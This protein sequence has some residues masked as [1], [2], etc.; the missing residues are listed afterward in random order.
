MNTTNIAQYLYKNVSFRV[1]K[2]VTRITYAALAPS[3]SCLLA[4]VNKEKNAEKTR[5]EINNTPSPILLVL[6][7]PFWI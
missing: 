5:V 6:P 2:Q 3:I 1:L 7:L 4:F